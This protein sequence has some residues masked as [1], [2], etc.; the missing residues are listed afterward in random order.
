MK[1]RDWTMAGAVLA[2]IVAIT[3]IAALALNGRDIETGRAARVRALELAVAQYS[4]AIE[5]A[6]QAGEWPS[7]MATEGK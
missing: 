3:L 1:D 6:K 2:V 7:P 4:G 5:R